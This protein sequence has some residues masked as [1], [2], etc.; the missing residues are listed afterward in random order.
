MMSGRIQSANIFVAL[1]LSCVSACGGSKGSEPAEDIVQPEVRQSENGI[2]DTTLEAVVTINS[3]PDA[4]TGLDKTVETHTYEGRLI[5]PTLR[6]VPGD[7]LHI[8]VVNS[9][10]A[11]PDQSRKGAFPHDPYTTNL[12]VH[13]MTVSQEGIGDNP[14]RHMLPQTTNAFEVDVPGYHRA[15]TFWYHPHKHGT[16]AFQFFGGMSGFLIVGRWAGHDRCSS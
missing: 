5:G 16:V 13:G 7:R 15:G 11:N 14:F 2:L 10:P 3:I 6:V 8:D 4:D 9:L 12:H 1:I